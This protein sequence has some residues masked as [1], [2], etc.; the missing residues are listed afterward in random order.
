MKSQNSV[1]ANKRLRVDHRPSAPLM[2]GRYS[3]PRSTVI[4]QPAQSGHISRPLNTTSSASRTTSVA[5]TGRKGQ[6]MQNPVNNH[7]QRR[8]PS[9]QCWKQSGT[10]FCNA[11]N[12]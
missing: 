2:K 1:R 3:G 11:R 6:E 9:G 7:F 4:Q 5:S 8:H 12:K 10:C